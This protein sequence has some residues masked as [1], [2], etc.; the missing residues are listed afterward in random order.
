MTKRVRTISVFAFLLIPIFFFSQC[1]RSSKIS[2]D[3]RTDGLLRLI[4]YMKRDHV[5][6]TP[7]AGLLEKFDTVEEELTGKLELF[8]ELSTSKQKVFAA[9]TKHSIIGHDETKK[10]KEMNVWKND[11]L[12]DF[13][14]EAEDDSLGWK[15]IK[16]SRDIDLSNEKNY[17]KQWKCLI[18]DIDSAFSF[19]TMLPNAPV[20]FEIYAQRNWHPVDL[21]ICIN[22]T[23]FCKK[24]I[25]NNARTY[26]I[27]KNNNNFGL[28]KITIK[29]SLSQI[30][31]D[32]RG[33][34]PPRLLI[35]SIRVKTRNDV[36]LFFIPSTNQN[37]FLKSRI[38]AKYLSEQYLSGD[39]NDYLDLYRMK[40]R[41]T[42]DPSDQKENP[43]NI[44]KIID[45][46][47]LSINVLMAPPTSR[48]NFKLNLPEE[49]FLEFGI[50]LYNEK[51]Y[52]DQKS[53]SFKILAE[54]EGTSKVVFEKELT[55]TDRRLR[56]Q[57]VMKKIT[58]APYARKKTKFSFITELP[59]SLSSNHIF[60]FW[61]NPLIY[62]RVSKRPNIILISLDTLR[63]DHLSCYGYDRNTSPYL[64]EFAKDSVLFQN[65]YVHSPWTLPSHVSMLY[66]LNS[67]NHQVYYSTQKIDV[68]LP[69]L[70][71]FLKKYGYITYALTGG[72]FVSSVFGFSK[73]FDWYE[74]PVGGHVPDEAKK[75]Y[76]YA[77]SWLSE[78]KD[79]Q[80][81]LFL[82]TF[83]IHGPYNPPPPWNQAFLDDSAKWKRIGLFNF[84]NRYGE[85]YKFTPEEKDN[86]IALYDGDI[87]YTDE[88]LIK[89][90]ISHLKELG[91]YDKT[92]LV[93]TSDH[94]E[95][96][97]EHNG[98]LHSNTLYEEILRVPLLIK[99][100]GS[101]FKGIQIKTRCRSIDIMPTIL[102]IA[103][104]K[105]DDNSLDGKSLMNLVLGK[106]SKDR[107]YI[108]DVAFKNILVPCPALMASNRENLKF[109]FE[110]SKTG[111]KDIE[112]YNLEKDEREKKNLYPKLE[113]I[114]EEVRISL[115]EYYKIRLKT[116]R[117]IENLKHDEKMK[118]KLRALGYLK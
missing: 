61:F 105:Y 118:E 77:S 2:S 60:P 38:K 3:L 55:L 8:P 48:F 109:I 111:I 1:G 104:V 117:N 84:L 43:Q 83:Q 86:I 64:D 115:D 67:A 27:Q 114:G 50:G 57:I 68:T 30:I 87:L 9:T 15:W 21:D 24:A 20:E 72:G 100:P 6:A 81:F 73:G 65:T 98:W 92:L 13:F 46:E 101:E 102:D 58:L 80:F 44:K 45:H 7:F 40:Y 113:K 29:P 99:F 18:M 25:D 14:E 75:L 76:G 85:D 11:N 66:S 106:E 12:M 49:S 93:I 41:F 78:N 71:Y 22:D 62:R 54:T 96:F 33:P 47:D 52:T 74:N 16:I 108:S 70:A 53:V 10:P 63:A 97:Y 69:S 19:E 95:E 89:P 88:M 28:Y 82:H 34:T 32:N 107:I 103:S 37:E 35:F 39:D 94:G 91:I 4:D 116:K 23:F 112:I 36:V 42:A 17:N 90:L 31:K 26:K 51:G 79:K 56:N 110:K 5:E 59:E